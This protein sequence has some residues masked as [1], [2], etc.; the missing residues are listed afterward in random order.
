MTCPC[1][2]GGLSAIVGG[3][4]KKRVLKKKANTKEKG[5]KGRKKVQSSPRKG[6]T[7]KKQSK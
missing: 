3:A 5:T 4:G 6:K 7:K 1:S 2:E